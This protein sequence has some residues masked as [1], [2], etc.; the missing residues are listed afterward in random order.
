ML[1]ENSSNNK[2]DYWRHL[3]KNNNSKLYIPPMCSPVDN[4]FSY[5][6]RDIAETLNSFFTSVSKVNDENAILPKFIA[7]T[8]STLDSVNVTSDQIKAL[9]KRL[10]LN[11]ASGPHLISHKMLKRAAKAVSKPL[12]IL[13]NRSLDESIFQ[14]S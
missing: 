5:T 7:K 6:E 8:D 9:I 12:T 4:K 14:D 10:N 11:K 13:F 3:V 2:R 1:L